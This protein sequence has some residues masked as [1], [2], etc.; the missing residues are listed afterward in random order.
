MGLPVITKTLFSTLL[1]LISMLILII[2]LLVR[3]VRAI[4][5][6]FSSDSSKSNKFGPEVD[7]AIW[8]TSFLT[9][10]KT[11][12]KYKMAAIWLDVN[13]RYKP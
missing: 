5:G 4:K 6:L 2:L 12:A 7:N 8:F 13:Q 9:G 10:A 1:P 3:G 11:G